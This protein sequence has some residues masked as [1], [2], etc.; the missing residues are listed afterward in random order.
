MRQHARNNYEN[1]ADK[2]RRFVK[3]AREL[4]HIAFRSAGSHSP[5]DV[6][7]IDKITKTIEF[8]QCKPKDFS[9]NKKRELE[10]EQKELSGLFEV[11][12]RVL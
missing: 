1:G 2:E 11:R 12:F 3:K 4:G 8:I 10:E 9:N 7:I 6:C 5:I